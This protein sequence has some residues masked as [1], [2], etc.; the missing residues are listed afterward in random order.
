MIRKRYL[1]TV[2]LLLYVLLFS[3][4]FIYS[5]LSGDAIHIQNSIIYFLFVFITLI[6]VIL[7]VFYVKFNKSNLMNISMLLMA[8]DVL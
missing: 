4:L 6:E 1:T 2:S 8:L 7:I 5:G 3:C